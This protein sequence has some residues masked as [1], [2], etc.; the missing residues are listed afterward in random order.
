MA[1][2]FEFVDGVGGP[3]EA[4]GG[5]GG[6]VF[7]G[8]GGHFAGLLGGGGGEDGVELGEELATL[9]VGEPAV[10]FV[11]VFD[12]GVGVHGGAGFGKPKLC[13]VV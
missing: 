6:E 9:V 7:A 3:D 5:E 13:L 4:G 2:G 11:A 12:V 10:V 1:G 8:E